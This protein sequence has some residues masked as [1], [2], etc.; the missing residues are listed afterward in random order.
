LH[1]YGDALPPRPTPLPY[2]TL[3]RSLEPG[4]GNGE[5]AQAA[6]DAGVGPQRDG[7]A[8]LLV[9]TAEEHHAQRD[10]REHADAHGHVRPASGGGPG[11][12]RFQLA[13]GGRSL[14]RVAPARDMD[15][16]PEHLADAGRAEPP[17]PPVE[18]TTVA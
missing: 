1:S 6:V 9:G 3:F 18:P 10:C 13:P 4:H 12:H 14:R 8:D 11:L 15:A 17:V 5:R 7:V 16:Q 2:T